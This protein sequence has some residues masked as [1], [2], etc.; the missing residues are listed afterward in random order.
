[1]RIS[2]IRYSRTS[3]HE[4]THMDV[5]TVLGTVAIVISIFGYAPYIYDIYRGK[6]KPHAFSW[7]IW[8]TLTAIAFA[9][10]LSDNGGIGAWPTGITALLSGVIFV[11]SLKYGE[12]NIVKS[13]WYYLIAAFIGLLLWPLAKSPLLSVIVVS[14]IDVLGFFPTF[15]KSYNRPFEETLSTHAITPIKHGLSTIALRNYSV[16]TV[17]YPLSLFI[18]SVV[19]VIMLLVRRRATRNKSSS[20][21]K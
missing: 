1:M 20:H 6:T 8:G 18:S 14:I 11:T 21:K 9:A 3:P 16:V 15:R 2:S 13:D 17:I 5:K 12:R 4:S 7:L 19:F 10:Q